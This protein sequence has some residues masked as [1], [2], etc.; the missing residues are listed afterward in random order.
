M[1]DID[2]LIGGK[3]GLAAAGGGACLAVR[4]AGGVV[5]GVAPWNPI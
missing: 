3:S 5:V 1:D 4:Q 2:L